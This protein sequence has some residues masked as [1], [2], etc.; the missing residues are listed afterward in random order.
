VAQTDL[1][2]TMYDLRLQA[3]DQ[4]ENLKSENVNVEMCFAKSVRFFAAAGLQGER[5]RAL[6]EWA[7]YEIERGNRAGGEL[8]WREVRAVFSRLDMD[9]DV[10]AMDA[11]LAL[12][13]A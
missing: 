6:R 1:R 10:R 3:V 12:S 13:D 8:L 11:F 9:G 2:F 7:R 4:I 5:A